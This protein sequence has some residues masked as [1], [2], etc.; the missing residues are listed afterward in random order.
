MGP[1][2]KQVIM[3]KMGKKKEMK[4][5]ESAPMPTKQKDD[6][7]VHNQTTNVAKT[8]FPWTVIILTAVLLLIIAFVMMFAG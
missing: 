6:G 2:I 8:R 1:D 5:S 7:K 4:A 3:E